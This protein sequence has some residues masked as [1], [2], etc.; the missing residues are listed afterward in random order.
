MNLLDGSPRLDHAC[1]SCGQ[2]RAH[3]CQSII[4]SATSDLKWPFSLFVRPDCID[5][6]PAV[7]MNSG[8]CHRRISSQWLFCWEHLKWWHEAPSVMPP[9]SSLHLLNFPS[10]Q[11]AGVAQ[12]SPQVARLRRARS[13]ALFPSQDPPPSRA[14]SRG[15]GAADP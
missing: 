8:W 1:R 5:H 15:N 11:T 2:R 3:R 10:Y 13:L 12:Q 14:S 6:S 7:E 9:H 4:L